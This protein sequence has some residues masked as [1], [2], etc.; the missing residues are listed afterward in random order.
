MENIVTNI[1]YITTINSSG[2]YYNSDSSDLTN[3]CYYVCL[4]TLINIGK[5]VR[6]RNNNN[7]GNNKW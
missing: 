5:Y 4:V 6:K 7:K 2:S 3:L 1:A